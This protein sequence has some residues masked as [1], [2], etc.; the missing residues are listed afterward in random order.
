MQA[1]ASRPKTFQPVL[2]LSKSDHRGHLDSK[3]SYQNALAAVLQHNNEQCQ[4][5]NSGNIS[6]LPNPWVADSAKT[7]CLMF[8]KVRLRGFR[9]LET[10]KEPSLCETMVFCELFWNRKR[11]R[12]DPDIHYSICAVICAQMHDW[13]AY[14]HNCKMRKCVHP[15]LMLTFRQP[16]LWHRFRRLYVQPSCFLSWNH[17][18]VKTSIVKS[19]HWSLRLGFI[20]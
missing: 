12:I 11:L 20:P 19:W 5:K 18:K 4:P 13:H 15:A 6:L 14:A 17:F 2:T 16:S 10:L 1:L 9:G 8:V 7:T 3:R